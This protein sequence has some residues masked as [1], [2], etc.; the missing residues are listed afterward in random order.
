MS[1]ADIALQKLAQ[2]RALSAGGWVQGPLARNGS[3]APAWLRDVCTG[4]S[5]LDRPAELADAPA[6][7]HDL[8][9]LPDVDRQAPPWAEPPA[10]QVRRVTLALLAGQGCL[11][12]PVSAE[13]LRQHAQD[14]GHADGTARHLALSA[15][16]SAAWLQAA[17]NAIHADPPYGRWLP[18]GAVD[19]CTLPVALVCYQDDGAPAGV[20]AQLTLYRV[21][22]RHARLCL[23]PVPA[24]ALLLR[25][26]SAWDDTL[27]DLQHQ[28][29]QVLQPAADS[30]LQHTAIAWDLARAD[31]GPLS[32]LQGNSAGCA[33]ALGAMWLMRDAAPDRWRALLTRLSRS[34]LQLAACTAALAPQ[35]GLGAVGGTLA[36]AEALAPLA[37]LVARQPHAKAVELLVSNAQN[38]PTQTDDGAVQHRSYPNLMALLTALAQ[39]ADPL[40]EPQRRLLA[41]LCAHGQAGPPPHAPGDPLL[42][43]VHD[44]SSAATTLRQYLLRCWATWER[45]QGGQVQQRWVALSVKPDARGWPHPLLN[46]DAQDFDDLPSLLDRHDDGHAGQHGYVLR[47]EP[48]AGKST[49]LRHHLQQAA[50]RLLLA[51][52]QPAGLH[53]P[54]AG[55]PPL[56]LPVYLPLADLPAAERDPWAWVQRHL[57]HRAPAAL[58]A[59]LQGS[60]EWARLGLRPRL[61]L[62]GLNELQVAHAG[63]RPDRARDV[64]QALHRQL[65]RPLPLLLAIRTE[66]TVALG[67]FVALQV[68]VLPW[69][70]RHIC[71]YLGLRFA[72]DAADEPV[73]PAPPG[74]PPDEAAWLGRQARTHLATLRRVRHALDLCRRPMHLAAQCDLWQAG[75]DAP[76]EDR[77]TLYAAWLWQRLRRALGHDPS[78]PVNPDA[79]I[80]KEDEQADPDDG[81]QV[82]LTAADHAAIAHPTLW[83]T[84]RLRHLPMQGLLLR[85]LVR[86]AADQWWTGAT[87]GRPAAE[88]SAAPQ[89]WPGVARW[90]DDATGQACLSPKLRRRWGAAAAT[91]GLVRLDMA[92]RLDTPG[93]A[94]DSHGAGSDGADDGNGV[95]QFAHQSWGEYLAS[96]SLLR[97]YP[98][99]DPQHLPAR[100]LGRLQPPALPFAGQPDADAQELQALS[101]SGSAAW[102]EVPQALWQ[103]LLKAP[104]PGDLPPLRLGL[105]AFVDSFFGGSRS[106]GEDQARQRL[107]AVRA[108]SGLGQNFNGGTWQAS[109]DELTIA[110]DLRRW[111]DST[112]VGISVGRAATGW[113]DTEA[114]GAG[115]QFLVQQRMTPAF[116]Q[117]LWQWLA[118]RLPRPGL[119]AELQAQQGRL[120]LPPAP[121]GAEVLGLA[122]TGQGDLP[123]LETW[124][125]ALMAQGLWPALAGVLPALQARLEPRGAWG[126][127]DSSAAAGAAAASS[128]ADAALPHLLLQH[129]RRVLLL[130]SVDAGTSAAAGLHANGTLALLDAEP[131]GF[132]HT[133]QAAGATAAVLPAALQAQW[134]RLRGAALQ[135]GGQRLRR[136]LQAGLLLGRLG[137]NLRYQWATGQLP[138]GTACAGL[139]PRRPLWAAVGPAGGRASA[140]LGSGPEGDASE[141]PRWRAELPAFEACT[142]PL[143]VGEWLPFWRSPHGRSFTWSKADDADFTN[144]LQPVTGVSWHAVRAYAAWAN[145]L[146]ADWHGAEAAA[147]CP[148]LRLALPT[149]LHWEV[150]TRCTGRAAAVE[151]PLI[152]PAPADATRF[153]HASTRWLRPSPVGVFGAS[154]TALGLQDTAGNVWAWCASSLDPDRRSRGWHDPA[155][156]VAARQAAEADDAGDKALRGG[157]YYVTSNRCRPAFR[158]HFTPDFHYYVIGVR[159]VRV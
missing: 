79:T 28:L 59:L 101:A 4:A 1:P 73:P 44:D 52:E 107:A 149:E 103:Q 140:W 61:L 94:D 99:A 65:V 85:S 147:R 138:D 116:Q 10:D 46:S 72:R 83:R 25:A 54:A 146:L 34:D 40:T 90:A 153:N 141:Q 5:Q 121:D 96:L 43:Q 142:L 49:L 33:F 119:L 109:A 104:A 110:A 48:G 125:Q 80:W 42:Q 56:E 51:L 127:G 6:A 111:G 137:D 3:L 45:W 75:F 159:L 88:G 20:A 32:V 77:A 144:P 152:E 106:R 13:A 57:A 122:L 148:P 78:Q 21:P 124:L 35:L 156:R 92:D 136:R 115:W 22:Q 19:S 126:R 27:A 151:P 63:Q 129:L 8:P 38:L 29:H 30:P 89:P 9:A 39:R 47:G 16:V 102:R 123:R 60:G 58:L 105:A 53:T 68:D 91:L 11:L 135:N 97:G 150:A 133:A 82:L 50:L 157:A 67:D 118:P 71:A 155:D 86:Q 7:L 12:P 117:A 31:G 113:A 41:H 15:G 36:K 130:T 95:W 128:E 18:Q 132:L 62:D 70:E 17:S 81:N 145:A 26:G 74:T 143:T 93:G 23:A 24:S 2:W 98:P 131:Q 69:D 108:H 139:R 114:R 64:V 100:L 76:A 154:A 120:D 37:A 87:P 66:H 134:L 112:G 84:T 14:A 158:V 55:A